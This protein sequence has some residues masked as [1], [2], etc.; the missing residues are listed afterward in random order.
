MTIG[1]TPL[2]LQTMRIHLIKE[3]LNKNIKRTNNPRVSEIARKVSEE[4]TLDALALLDEQYKAKE[5]RMI[6]LKKG[7]KIDK[8]MSFVDHQP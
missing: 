4:K 5:E 1:V 3:S 7:K 2:Q 6:H 8:E